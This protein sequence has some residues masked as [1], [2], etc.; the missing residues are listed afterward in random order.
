MTSE[1]ALIYY[2]LSNS[3]PRILKFK[4]YIE[5]TKSTK[6]SKAIKLW[7]IFGA[8]LTGGVAIAVYNMAPIVAEAGKNLN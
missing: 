2:F 6:L 1:I 5:I 7:T 4:Y 3:P 8:L